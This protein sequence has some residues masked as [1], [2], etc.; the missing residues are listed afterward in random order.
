M[1]PDNYKKSLI[2]EISIMIDDRTGGLS[3]KVKSRYGGRFKL[4]RMVVLFLFVSSVFIVAPACG[5]GQEADLSVSP[6]DIEFSNDNPETGEIVIIDVTV[7]NLGPSIAT[8]V[9]VNFYL[10]G[11]PL[12]PSKS[13]AQIVAG[14]TG[15]T[16]HQWVATIPGVYSIGVSVSSDQDD[17]V[18][19]NNE[20]ERNITVGTAAPTITVT[21]TASPEVIQSKAMFW[22]NG[23][24]EM[25]GEPV[26]G[27]EARAEVVGQGIVNTS[28]T[29]ADGTFAIH[30][31]APTDQSNY[32]VQVSVTLTVTGSTMLNITV[33]QPDMAVNTLTFTPEKDVRAGDNVKIRVGIQN[34]G[35]GTAKGVKVILKIDEQEVKT[36]DEGDL[37][38][39]QTKALTYVWKAQKGSHSFQAT[40]DP[41]DTIEEIQ[42]DNNNKAATLDVKKKKDEPTPSFEVA[43][44]L[45][46]VVVLFFLMRNGNG[47]ITRRGR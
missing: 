29:A 10:M 38:N 43:L 21:A 30:I 19:G 13:I 1:I 46:S 5:Q 39:G 4:T 27:G 7:H 24:A 15:E 41:G 26:D 31:Q 9:N 25:N 35:N 28:T 33:L 18:P 34:L 12:P 47:P 37:V 6:S 42:E 22:V 44:F 16:S 32:D 8:N 36:W 11:A 2:I 17:P 23:S 45:L 3:M 20:A 14:S 40:V